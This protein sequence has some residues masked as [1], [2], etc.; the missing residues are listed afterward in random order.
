MS[1]RPL[2]LALTAIVLSHKTAVAQDPA[3]EVAAV[4][5]RY[6]I[7]VAIAAANTNALARLL[8]S[9]TDINQ[10]TPVGTPLTWAVSGNQAA[11]LALL[12]RRGALVNKPDQKGW[13]PIHC[14]ITADGTKTE[15]LR[16]LLSGGALVDA[17]DRHQKTAL[18]RAAQFGQQDTVRMLLRY[19]ANPL[20]RDENGNTARDR[21]NGLNPTGQSDAGT[22]EILLEAEALANGR[23]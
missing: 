14:A 15:C 17:T 20:L 7:L 6:P 23:K 21:A 4:A 18:H 22:A 1:V 3:R 11:C 13:P 2:L 8:D 19:G 9:G 5:A 16:L 10:S 12:L